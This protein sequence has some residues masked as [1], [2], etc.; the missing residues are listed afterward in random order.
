MQVAAF[1][2]FAISLA[3][4]GSVLWRLTP[5]KEKPLI[6]A[7]LVATLPMCWVMFH[8]VRMPLDGW[9]KS[10]FGQSEWL[11]WLRTA[12][13]PLTEEPAKLWPLLVPVVRRAIT[14]E[15][16]GRFAFALGLGFGLG[17]IFTVAGLIAARDPGVAT[18][19][20]YQLYGFIG[21]RFLVCGIHGGFTALAL[22]SWRRGPGFIV[23]L[24]LAMTAHYFG[25]FPITMMQ[26]GWLGP[27]IEFAKLLIFLW[28]TACF[29]AALVLISWLQFGKSSVGR[30]IHGDTI[31]PGCQKEYSRSV[32]GM[33]FGSTLRF[34]RCPHCCK[35]HW[36]RQKPKASN[37]A[38]ASSQP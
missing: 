38:P 29:I 2:T 12:Y 5:P 9:L 30:L 22:A 26:R 18:M 13:A 24:L 11:R 20:W 3:V 17:E 21:E 6:L 34:E 8:G 19:P 35:W 16:V 15:S 27:N 32:F 31:C 37:P 14:R 25:N 1:I 33:N 28:T 36:T 10:A 23:G 4:F 7:C